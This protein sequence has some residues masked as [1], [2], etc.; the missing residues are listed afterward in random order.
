MRL[1]EGLSHDGGRAPQARHEQRDL[2]E[3]VAV[4]ERGHLVGVCS[5]VR[6]S[7]TVRVCGIVRDS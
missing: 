1:A 3:T 7:S 5:M 6:D 4:G 2:A